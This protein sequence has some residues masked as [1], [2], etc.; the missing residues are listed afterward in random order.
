MQNSVFVLDTNHQPLSPCR[1]SVA[2]KLLRDGKAAVWRRYPFTLILKRAVVCAAPPPPVTVKIDPGSQT[3][4]IALVQD[5]KVVFAAEL[6]HR[7]Q[8]IRSALDKRRAVRRNRRA[9][10]C[11]YRATRFANRTRPKGWLPPSL[12][13]RVANV[14]TWVARFARLA[15]VARLSM[16]LVKF[17]TQLMQNAEISGI[18][19]QQ[20]ELAGYEIREY[21]LEK[22]ERK[23]AYCGVHGVPLEVEHI[24][25]RSRGGGKRVSNLTLACHTC[26]QAKN[27][28]TAAEF[29]HPE[30]QARSKQ[31]L[32]DAAA[33]NVTR[34]ALWRALS[35]FEL[36]LETG[37]GGRTK[38]NRTRQGYPKAHWID[39]ACV[40][41]SGTQV[42]VVPTLV[43]L[44]VKATGRG[45]RQMCLLDKYGFP[46]TAAKSVRRVHG[47][48]TGDLVEAVVPSGKYS[49]VQQGRVAIRATGSFRI[50]AA[51]GISWRHCR[52]VQAVDGY[53]YELTE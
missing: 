24:T 2:R 4:G 44:N 33:V 39:A 13:S 38:F 22:W 14:V 34:W 52:L 11:R 30:V 40:G 32:C 48:Q 49:G 3:T 12:H 7:G 23:C 28:Q 41:V 35:A 50:G 5:G 27:N 17:D 16:E 45:R 47:F 18:A 31:P 19:Y 15:P 46:R 1:P 43:A 25:P 26:N 29:G 51:D 9:R 6:T 20:G 53:A 10:H 36:P 42:R 8:T 37:T 21:L